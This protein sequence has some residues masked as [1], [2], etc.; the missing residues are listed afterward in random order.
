[1]TSMIRLMLDPCGP[2]SFILR[3][4][5]HILGIE[6]RI[7]RTLE[8]PITLNLA[9]LHEVLQAAF[10]WTDSHLHQFNI[11]GLIYGAPEFDEDGLFDSRIFEATEVKM[12]DFHFPYEADEK[13]ITILYEYDFGDNWRH[14]L[15]LER[16]PRQEGAKYPRCIAASRSAPPED[17][18][19]TS[20]YAEFLEAWIDPGHDEHKS[21]H[22]WAGHKFHPEF[23]DLE[24][25]NKA[26]TKAL[27]SS[28]GG[29]RF[30]HARPS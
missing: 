11:G 18:G 30:R 9:Q 22:R 28:R 24:A 16:A 20:G 27:R 14:L 13:P 10:G 23:C 29:Y 21:M 15:R 6:P 12:I 5:V 3:A 8:L 19:G 25:I 4:D 2:D 17:V 26:I 7:S 1:M